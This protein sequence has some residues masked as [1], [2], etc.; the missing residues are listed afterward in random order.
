MSRRSFV[1]GMN[2]PRPTLIIVERG[3]PLSKTILNNLIPSV[4][5]HIMLIA[6]SYVNYI[7]YGNRQDIVLVVDP[8]HHK[9][10]S[11]YDVIRSLREQ[12]QNIALTLKPA[13][14][15][16][17]MSRVF[18]DISKPISP[19]PFYQRRERRKPPYY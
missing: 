8:I 9:K 1:L 18:A 13:E 19:R 14:P 17:S 7:R 6:R 10:I 15:A 16:I 4:M 3:K 2:T 11:A 5:V 12:R